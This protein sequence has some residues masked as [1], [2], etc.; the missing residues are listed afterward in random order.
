MDS[1]ALEQ[2]VRPY[3]VTDGRYFR[4]GDVDPGDTGSMDS[5]SKD[6]AREALVE[7]IEWLADQQAMLAAQDRWGLL[8]IFQARDAAGKDSTIKHVMRGINPQGCRVH[9]FK[10]PSSEE[11]RHDYLWRY[12]EHIPSRGEIG[13]FNR[14]YYEE[15]LVVRVHQELLKNQKLAPRLVTDD[16]WKQRYEDI[17]NFEQY[18][19]RNG[20]VTLKF[21]LHVSPDEQK[22]RFLA[23][24]E[25]PEKHW[26]F[27]PSD[28]QERRVWNEYSAAYEKMIQNTASEDAPWYVIPADKKW[29]TRLVVAGAICL[30]ITDLELHYP[31]ISEEKYDKLQAARKELLRE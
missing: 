29:F 6:E 4:L 21:F 10:Q 1:S 8:T 15:I 11:L 24:L 12:H 5:E 25:E 9:S 18:L 20:I 19:A 27:S 3:R 30:R 28:I 14:S 16:I 13:I 17:K 26:K 31:L 7:G 22:K 2:F 23:R